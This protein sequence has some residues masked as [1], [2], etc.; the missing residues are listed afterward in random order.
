MIESNDFPNI[1][2]RVEKLVPIID[3]YAMDDVAMATFCLS[4]CVNNRSALESLL[5]LNWALANH[6]C[7]GEK[8]IDEY[9]QFTS[10]FAEIVEIM[11]PDAYMDYIEED[12]GEVKIDVFGRAYPVI[13]GTGHNLVFACLQFLVKL[14]VDIGR[15]LSD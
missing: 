5:A 8:R 6:S 1:M 10:F 12:F 4:V 7:L 15:L 9:E 14:K 3:K 2:E 13:V 11:K